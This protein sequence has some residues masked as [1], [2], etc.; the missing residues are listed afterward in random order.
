MNLH[1]FIIDG[2]NDFCD[3]PDSLLPADGSRPQ[4]PVK[5]AHD[6]M[7]RLA[8]FMRRARA[9]VRAVTATFDSHA[10]V[11]IERPAFWMTGDGEP[12]APFTQ[13]TAN[14]VRAGRYLPRRS[15]LLEPVLRYLDALEAGGKY[16]LMVWTTHCV[17]GTWGHALHSAVAAEVAAWEALHLQ[18]I[19]RV[20]KGL[21]PMTEQYSAVRA[22]VPLVS[23]ASTDTN[24][25]LI[26]RVVDHTDLLVVA[27][28]ASS[29][30][31]PATVRDV[32]ERTMREDF[33]RRVVVL[34]DCMSPVGGF[35]AAQ[36]AFFEEMRSR[37][38][39]VMTSEELARELGL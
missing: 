1:L 29:H 2:Q 16:R 33:A 37:G 4:L 30:C 21:N 27:G 34:S 19:A 22:E 6:D 3:L 26:D 18:P 12:V 11:G 39:R 5:G 23:D 9:Q 20:L 8:A 7:L 25:A 38:A 14:E 32:L 28:E 13:I 35:E 31:V 10:S 36:D 15:S 24:H 17:L